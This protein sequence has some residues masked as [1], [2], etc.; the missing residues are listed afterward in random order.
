MLLV[1]S[2]N[3][4]GCIMQIAVFL[5]TAGAWGGVAII[6][7]FLAATVRRF[8]LV[9]LVQARKSM[10]RNQR[11]VALSRANNTYRWNDETLTR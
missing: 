10:R 3:Y 9:A 11:R 7:A 5:I 2:H 6:L 1:N 8:V 4:E